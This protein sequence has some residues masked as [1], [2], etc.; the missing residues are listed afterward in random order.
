ME[1]KILVVDDEKEIRDFL[2]KALTRLGGF[3]VS[4]AE[5]GEEALKKIAQEK[6]DLVLTD[7]KMPVL[8]GLQLITEISRLRPETL[9]VLMTGHGTIDSAIEAMKQGASDYLTKP[10]NLDE[11]L[12]RLRKALE[13]RQRF[14]RMRD[15]VEQLEKANQE[16]RKID[17]MKSEFV[18]IASHELRT[19][20]AAIKNAIQLILSGKTG[21]INEHQTRFLS[22]ADRNITR[23][24]NI[25]NDL[26][27]LSKIESGKI[28][29]KLERTDLKPLIDHTLLSIKPQAD[30]KSLRLETEVSEGLPPV[31]GDREKIEQILVNLIGNAIKFTP[32]GG[33]IS[34]IAKWFSEEKDCRGTPKIAISVRDTGIGIPAEH[35]HAVFEKFFQVEGSLHRSSGGTG[36]GLAITKGLVEAHRGK[37]WVESEVGKGSTFTFTLPIYEEVRREPHFRFV[38]EAEIRRAQKK[39]LPLSL[40]LIEFVDRRPKGGEAILVELEHRIRQSLCR[41]SDMLMRREGEAT[42]VALCEADSKGVQSIRQRMEEDLRK[43]PLSGPDGPLRVKFGWAS[44]PEEA[45]TKHELFRKARERLRRD[46]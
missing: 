26:L 34:V 24:T 27:N 22:M 3:R 25:L 44:F 21:P 11:M 40:L 45:S 10:L 14:V 15:Y 38:L 35:L 1:D 13:E 29:L 6:F 30:G 39:N 7:L 31:Y 41:K 46:A 33:K 43:N 4:L 16:L 17:A 9:T 23:L 37:I 19:P 18:S 20:L 8:D 12:L 2:F 5:N 28:E 42:L 36:L 32:E